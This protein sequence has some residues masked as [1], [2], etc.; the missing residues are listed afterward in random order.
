MVPSSSLP[1]WSGALFL[2]LAIVGLPMVVI[3]TWTFDLTPGL[4]NC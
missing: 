2:A 3:L 1:E 4:P